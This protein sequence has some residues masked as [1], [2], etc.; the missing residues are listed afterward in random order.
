M[1]EESEIREGGGGGSRRI[2]Y[3]TNSYVFP[4]LKKTG[5]LSIRIK[6]L[7]H[8]SCSKK[9]AKDSRLGLKCNS[10]HISKIA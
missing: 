3:F 5:L 2:F 10:P 1:V 7:F 8:K 6:E 9:S 4:F